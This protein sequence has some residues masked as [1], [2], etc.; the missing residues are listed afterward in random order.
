MAIS[1]QQRINRNTVATHGVVTAGST[2]AVVLIPEN[3]A[4]INVIITN[5]S[6]Q[7]CWVRFKTAATDNTKHGML[8]DS[9]SPPYQ[10]PPSSI[11]PGEISVIFEN[12]ANNDISF[13]EY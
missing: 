4:R 1:L 5:A 11:Y 6:N 9:G 2:T 3:E 10:M 7:A 8:L 13:I 12:G